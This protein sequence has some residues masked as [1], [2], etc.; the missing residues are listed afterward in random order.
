M[1]KDD[2]A[3]SQVQAAA[4]WSMHLPSVQAMWLTRLSAGLASP[5]QARGRHQHALAL[6]T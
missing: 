2:D 6:H 3:A 5:Q 1:D 4:L